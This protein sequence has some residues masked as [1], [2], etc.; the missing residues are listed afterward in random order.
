[1]TDTAENDSTLLNELPRGVALVDAKAFWQ[2]AQDVK[3]EIKILLSY[4]KIKTKL[5]ACGSI[6]LRGNF[7]GTRFDIRD[8]QGHP[9]QTGCV[10]LKIARWV[11]AVFFQHGFDSNYWPQQVRNE[12][13]A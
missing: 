12:I 7:F 9:V 6:N 3:N 2:A 5:L 10:R 8:D 1:M 13:F 11:L 4:S